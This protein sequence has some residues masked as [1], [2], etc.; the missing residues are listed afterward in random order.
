M[1]PQCPSTGQGL[2]EGRVWGALGKG[3]GEGQNREVDPCLL[4]DLMPGDSE[5]LDLG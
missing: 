5:R 1:E 2:G 4:R 3:W